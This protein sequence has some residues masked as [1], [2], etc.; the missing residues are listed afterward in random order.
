MTRSWCG[1]SMSGCSVVGQLDVEGIADS[2]QLLLRD[3]DSVYQEA[4]AE[5]TDK[6]PK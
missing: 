6:G 1:R 2:G 5:V 3:S 4:G